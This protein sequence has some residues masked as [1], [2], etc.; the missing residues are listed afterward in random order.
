MNLPVDLA[1]LRQVTEGDIALESELFKVFLNS[2]KECIGALRLHCR[3][4]NQEEWR[5]HAHAFKSISYGIGALRLAD[6]CRQAQEGFQNPALNKYQY[7]AGIEAE[8]TEVELQLKS[9]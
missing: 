2:A 9:L 4:G 8:F 7:L 6:L 5:R 3:S 1:V